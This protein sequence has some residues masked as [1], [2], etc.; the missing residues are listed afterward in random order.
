V[1]AQ[2]FRQTFVCLCKGEFSDHFLIT[3]CLSGA[4]LGGTVR[5]SSGTACIRLRNVASKTLLL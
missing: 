3:A 1:V 5:F 2:H 4:V